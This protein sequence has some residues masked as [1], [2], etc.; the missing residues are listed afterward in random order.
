MLAQPYWPH[1]RVVYASQ[2]NQH[3]CVLP[4]PDERDSQE[5]WMLEFRAAEPQPHFL[6]H[7]R[8][9]ADINSELPCLPPSILI[10]AFR[11]RRL[12]DAS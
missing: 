6:R 8:N 7:D 5:P 3:T 4:L 9:I 2:L 11:K 12:L 10:V 1:A